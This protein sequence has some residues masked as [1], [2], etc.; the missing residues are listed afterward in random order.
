MESKVFENYE[1]KFGMIFD[2]QSSDK[3]KE[4]DLK[5]RV[6]LLGEEENIDSR[7]ISLLRI[8][9]YKILR[10][11][12]CTKALRLLK[13]FSPNFVLFVGRIKENEKGEY[14]IEL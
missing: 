11:K 2:H 14:V 7:F 10:V 6:L 9:G 5:K 8:N 13:K 4:R 3:L 12:H 1:L